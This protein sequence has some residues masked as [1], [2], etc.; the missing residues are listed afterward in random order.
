MGL[1]DRMVKEK[2]YARCF[3]HTRMLSLENSNYNIECYSF[4]SFFART[5]MYTLYIDSLKQDIITC[6]E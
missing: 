6:I 2:E 5:S 1:F 4:R 3:L